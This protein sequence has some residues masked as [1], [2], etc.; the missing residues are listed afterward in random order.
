MIDHE[1]SQEEFHV[2]NLSTYS[3]SSY[4]G[5]GLF[6]TQLWSGDEVVARV[7]GNSSEEA[8]SRAEAINEALISK[9]ANPKTEVIPGTGSPLVVEELAHELWAAAQLSP[10]E[11]IEDGI[12]RITHILNE[13]QGEQQ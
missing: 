7:Y 3:L 12:D 13:R 4:T 9:A 6:F 1:F 5:L 8:R 10:G 11:S 2:G